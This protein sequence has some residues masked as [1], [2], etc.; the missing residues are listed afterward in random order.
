MRF[1]LVTALFLLL[2]SFTSVPL[3]AEETGLLLKETDAAISVFHNGKVLLTY[4]KKSPKV[5][6][7][8]KPIFQRSACL[9][10]VNTPA[11]KTITA[12][13]PVDHPHQNGIFT[14]WTKTTYDGRAIDFWNLAKGQ[15]R[16]VH[17]KTLATDAV[18]LMGW[19]VKVS[20]TVSMLHQIVEEPAV[21]V[22]R[23]TW[24]VTVRLP[25]KHE[26][27][28]DIELQ[29]E[30]LT[31]KPLIIEKYHY[32]GFAI[33]G[34]TRWVLPKDGDAKKGEQKYET[35]F[36]LN[37][38]GSNRIKGNHEH[39]DW[40]AMSGEIDGVGAS[41]TATGDKGNF[42]APQAARLHPTK[43]YF[44]F[45]PCVDGEF[46]IDKKSPYKA[47]YTITVSN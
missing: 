3:A 7:G 30:A 5:P 14:A 9:H 36:F 38:L 39:A 10:P 46:V 35:N 11:G 21:D 40:V 27:E 8:I 34:P 44:C 16:V 28:F 43:P 25:R 15:G 32:G 6:E 42:R 12:M 19:N 45:A 26:Y 17:E 47:K 33:R 24:K 37:S 2:Q 18:N 4:N 31:D 13:F 1:L 41:I 20:F 22:L 23:E 29:Q